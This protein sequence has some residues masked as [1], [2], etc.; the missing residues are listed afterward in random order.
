MTK[1]IGANR[2]FKT[3]G[4][5]F[6][7]RENSRSKKYN[8]PLLASIVM[9]RLTPTLPGFV[10]YNSQRFLKKKQRDQNSYLPRGPYFWQIGIYFLLIL[11]HAIIILT[12]HKQFPLQS[13]Y[14]CIFLLSEPTWK[15]FFKWN[16]SQSCLIKKSLCNNF[17]FACPEPNGAWDFGERILSGHNHRNCNR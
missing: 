13:V 6:L 14:V 7:A 15:I 5:F 1:S 4:Y 17:R 3:I 12:F 8:W 16:N 11:I 10:S 2:K 9:Y